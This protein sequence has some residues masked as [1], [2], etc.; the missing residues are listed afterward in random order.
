MLGCGGRGVGIDR[1]VGAQGHPQQQRDGSPASACASDPTRGAMSGAK[2]PDSSAQLRR[3]RSA[4]EEAARST[5]CEETRWALQFHLGL[6]RGL[7]VG[8]SDPVSRARAMPHGGGCLATGA[9]SLQRDGGQKCALRRGRG[10]FG[11]LHQEEPLVCVRRSVDRYQG[12]SLCARLELHPWCRSVVGQWDRSRGR[13]YRCEIAAVRGHRAGLDG[14]DR[15]GLINLGVLRALPCTGQ[16][17]R[18]DALPWRLVQRLWPR[19]CTRPLSGCS[20]LRCWRLHSTSF[21][22]ARH[23]WPEVHLGTCRCESG[24]LLGKHECWAHGML[25]SR[26]GALL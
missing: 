15:V 13:R 17:L 5:R 11:T 19:G 20:R 6:S 7:R 24:L 14:D 1:A 26:C 9:P 23:R 22:H 10:V 25:C 12:P 3:A 16:C 2:L 8:P 21:G 4:R 18:Q